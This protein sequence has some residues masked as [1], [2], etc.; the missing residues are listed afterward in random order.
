MALMP[1]RA[2][3]R[4]GLALPSRS[5]TVGGG[6]CML[7][8]AKNPVHMGV[9][10]P[11]LARSI[12]SRVHQRASWNSPGS[13]ARGC[14]MPPDKTNHKLTSVCWP[15]LLTVWV[16]VTNMGSSQVTG[17][18]TAPMPSSSRASRR[19]VAEGCCSGSTWPLVD[20]HSLAR[21]LCDGAVGRVI[22]ACARVLG[23]SG[24]RTPRTPERSRRWLSAAA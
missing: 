8:L 12:W 7:E 19:T 16:T 6:A 22:P 5:G 15:R 23:R 1:L 14:L 13:G 24:N 2:R 3:I 18:N 21:Q 10:E 20:S 11:G 17:E 4:P 9:E